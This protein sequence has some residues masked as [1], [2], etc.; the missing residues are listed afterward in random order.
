M[1]AYVY[2]L[3][4]VLLGLEYCPLSHS[5]SLCSV[6]YPFV[7]HHLD[8]K[9]YKNLIN[10]HKWNLCKINKRNDNILTIIPFSFINYHR[11]IIKRDSLHASYSSWNEG[12]WNLYCWIEFTWTYVY[13][14]THIY[15]HCKLIYNK[16]L[17]FKHCHWQQK[18]RFYENMDFNDSI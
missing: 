6:W 7:S 1:H 10:Y 5:P 13:I 15:K 11:Y 2:H 17:V 18:F 12:S 8:I 16:T 9:I 4:P 14:D 3:Q